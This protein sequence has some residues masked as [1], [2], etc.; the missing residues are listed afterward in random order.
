MP[1][2]GAACPELCF[3]GIATGLGGAWRGGTIRRPR[4]T[5]GGIGEDRWGKMGTGEIIA[6]VALI[7]GLIS[8]G[9]FVYLVM[10]VE[11]KQ[12]VPDGGAKGAAMAPSY[13]LFG[14]PFR[15][16][17]TMEL[18]FLLAGI[19]LSTGAAFRLSLGP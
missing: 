2:Q 5:A 11:P 9:M 7:V 6:T 4:R 17:G 14:I 16:L 12:S 3:F 15:V 18:L 8:L 1:R 10:V 19:V 13:R